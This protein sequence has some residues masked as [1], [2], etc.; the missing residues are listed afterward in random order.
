[1]LGRVV[2]DKLLPLRSF[3]PFDFGDSDDKARHNPEDIIPGILPEPIVFSTRKDFFSRASEWT[4][5]TG[6]ADLISLEQSHGIEKGVVIEG[7]E[8]KSYTLPNTLQYFQRLMSNESYARDVH[9]LLKRS[10]AGH[11]YFVTGFLTAKQGTFSEFQLKSRKTGIEVT[12]PLL[13]AAGIPT[14]VV[15]GVG[16]PQ[17]TPAKSQAQRLERSM[18]ILDEVIVA[19]SYDVIRSS[20]SLDFGSRSLLKKSVLNV[21]PKRAKANHLAFA[22]RFGE[23]FDDSDDSDASDAENPAATARLEKPEDDEITFVHTDIF[24]DTRFDQ[25]SDMSSASF[26]L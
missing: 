17:I 3:V 2:E 26:R 10:K 14:M 15:G 18:T 21:G 19:V 8:V 5:G 12:V 20:R 25:G 11:A 24:G 4:L 7:G 16:N 1:M 6:L 9:G 13:E 22:G 23:D